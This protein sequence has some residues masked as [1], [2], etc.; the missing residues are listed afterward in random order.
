MATLSILPYQ[1][2]P[3]KGF[4]KAKQAVLPHNLTLLQRNYAIC[5]KPTGLP[6]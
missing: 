5:P 2:Q 3:R 1:W 4:V 6:A